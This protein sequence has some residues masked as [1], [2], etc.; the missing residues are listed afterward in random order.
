[1]AVQVFQP[2]RQESDLDQILRGLQLVGG[3][4]N[5]KNE[6]AEA[7]RLKA[8]EERNAQAGTREQEAFDLSK[9]AAARK[10]EK[11]ERLARGELTPF[12]AAEAGLVEAP[13]G[14][15][16]GI[17]V[18][19][20]RLAG[21]IGPSAGLVRS[22]IPRSELQAMQQAQAKAEESRI[23]EIDRV[24]SA[25]KEANI[26]FEKKPQTRDS[27]DAFARAKLVDDL[28]SE[29][30]AQSDEIALRQLFRMSGDVGAIRDQDIQALGSDP[31]V[32]QQFK[33]TYGRLKEGDVLT[34]ESREAVKSGLRVMQAHHAKKLEN[35]A[36]SFSKKFASSTRGVSDE[37]VFKG[38][39]IG[40]LLG[41]ELNL[42]KER[43]SR[44]NI[45]S[46][47]RFNTGTP[48][49]AIGSTQMT[50]EEELRQR[51]QQLKNA[52]GGR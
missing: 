11:E 26:E 16:G 40:D 32:Y 2:Q 35:S 20:A 22:M 39:E 48:G 41:S 51:V 6:I 46:Q 9:Q 15:V 5:I 52:Q 23:A 3:V 47:D 27:T 24:K 44:R 7:E 25:V 33:S 37:D 21:D 36:K 8:Q 38:L 28:L 10:L 30:T 49:E 29:Q 50:R 42:L 4:L 1:M 31:S 14:M 17:P 12:E 18:R 45:S 34:P 13:K 19:E 43:E